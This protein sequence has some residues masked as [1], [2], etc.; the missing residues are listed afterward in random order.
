MPG[1]SCRQCFLADSSISNGWSGY[2]PCFHVLSLSAPLP[3][4]SSAP[5]GAGSLGSAQMRKSSLYRTSVLCCGPEVPGSPWCQS[6]CHIRGETEAQRKPEAHQESQSGPFSFTTGCGVTVETIPSAPL[7]LD[8]CP[9]G[10]RCC[11]C[12]AC[13][14]HPLSFCVWERGLRPALHCREQRTP[15][16]PGV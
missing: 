4:L 12:R 6:S 11:P 14:V 3:Q 13:G 5:L 15:P 16:R 8:C 2:Q 10:T 1:P 7:G 9:V